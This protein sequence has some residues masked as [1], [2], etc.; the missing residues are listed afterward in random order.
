MDKINTS[1][2]NTKPK[3]SKSEFGN[4]VAKKVGTAFDGWS[5]GLKT[6]IANARSNPQIGEKLLAE[7]PTTRVWEIRLAPGERVPAHIHTTNYF[8]TAITPG[9]ARSHYESGDTFEV[10]YERGDTQHFIFEGGA[11]MVHDLENIGDGELAF[12]TVELLN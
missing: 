4:A 7:T 11:V 3:I 8:W 2:T 9:S 12:I 1:S 6:E 10:D 5:D